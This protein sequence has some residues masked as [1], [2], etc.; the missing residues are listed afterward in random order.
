M[1]AAKDK[2]CRVCGINV[3]NKW[4]SEKGGCIIC[5]SCGYKFERWKESSECIKV[6]LGQANGYD[7]D[8]NPVQYSVR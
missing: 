8:G 2:T 5:D 7:S 1:K 3:N 6:Y 4:H